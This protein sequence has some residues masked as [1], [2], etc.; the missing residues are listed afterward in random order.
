MAISKVKRRNKTEVKHIDPT[1]VISTRD[2]IMNLLID[3]EDGLTFSEV[4]KQLPKMSPR[5][6]REQIQKLKN[7]NRLK[8]ETC[9]C[10]SST[11]Y[12]PK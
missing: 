1:L 5:N 11:I 6:I 3:S 7:N 9:R 10:K 8:M 4:Y 2:K 12:Y